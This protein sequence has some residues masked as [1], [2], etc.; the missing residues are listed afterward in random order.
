MKNKIKNNWR[1]GLTVALVSIPLSVSLAMASGATPTVG[2]ITAFVAG[3]I[4][5]IFAGSQFN[6][7]GPTGALTGL[8][9]TFTLSYGIGLLPELTFITGLIII[10]GYFLRIEKYL[11]YVPSSVI[12]GFTLGIAV[13]LILNQ[14]NFILGLYTIPSKSN[15]LE[16]LIVAYQ[17][18]SHFDYK[19]LLSFCLFLLFLYFTR[20]YKLKI[21]GAIILAP[22]VILLGY[23]SKS[24][25]IQYNLFT[26]GD[27]FQ[28]I[29]FSFSLAKEFSF[30]N[31]II[32]SAGTIAFVGIIETMLSAK[33]A[34]SMTHLKHNPRKEL[35]AL[36]LANIAS[37]IAGGMPATAA[38]ARTSLNIRSGAN[39]KF[40]GIFSG[41]FIAVI[42]FFLLN[43]FKYLPMTAIAAILVDTAIRMVESKHFGKL[44][45]YDLPSYVVALVVALVTVIEDPI[46][47]IALGVAIAFFLFVEKTSHG[48]F[49]IFVND[50]QGLVNSI[51]GDKLKPLKEDGTILLYSI[52]G[53]LLYVNCAAHLSRFET[54]IFDKFN[55]VIIR[56][57]EVFQMDMDGIEAFDAMIEIL[58]SK[59]KSVYISSASDQLKNSLRR[60]SKEFIYLENHGF[61]FN[62]TRFALQSL[63]IE[64]KY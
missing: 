52:R 22:I 29:K 35:L 7:I 21:P 42:S 4:G 36:G 23:L 44:R 55:I 54:D 19:S 32:I 12:H 63:G 40:S 41:I 45:K 60:Q 6:I 16:T 9:A 18:L 8:T 38:L 39:N 49:E 59:G 15:S 50:E 61:V 2:I 48:H 10:I 34:D 47:G 3:T 5:A 25:L 13:I 62:K 26:L 33:I 27:K 58:K 20:K 37:G 14:T 51:S 17:N 53:N 57:R 1:S 11:I 64:T 46:V 43:Q 31:Q 56:L 24:Q 28:D 30:H